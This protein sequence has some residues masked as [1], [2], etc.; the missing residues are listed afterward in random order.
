MTTLA[1]A[2]NAPVQ[3]TC[4]IDNSGAVW[5]FGFGDSGELGLGEAVTATAVPLKVAGLGPAAAVAMGWGH[6]CV[7]LQDG[8]LRCWGRDVTNELG[9]DAPPVSEPMTVEVPVQ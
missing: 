1:T 6:T 9:N 8:G 5:C 2:G 3:H 7:A 4:A